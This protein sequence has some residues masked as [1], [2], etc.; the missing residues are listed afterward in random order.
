MIILISFVTAVLPKENNRL[1]AIARDRDTYYIAVGMLLP[2]EIEFT[3]SKVF[4]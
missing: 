2:F 3:L 1:S 4:E